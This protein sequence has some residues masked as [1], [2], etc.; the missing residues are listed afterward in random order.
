MIQSKI[1]VSTINLCTGTK[2]AVKCY[3]DMSRLH[4]MNSR[5]RKSYVVALMFF[6]VYMVWMIGRTINYSKVSVEQY[7]CHWS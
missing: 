3:R 4:P 1:F 7:E 5:V 6:D 2:S